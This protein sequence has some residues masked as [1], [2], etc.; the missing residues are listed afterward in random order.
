MI[1][2]KTKEVNGVTILNGFTWEISNVD[3]LIVG[4]AL[5]ILSQTID[6]HPSDRKDARRIV[7][8]IERAIWEGGEEEWK[9]QNITE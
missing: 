1:T 4:K 7:E 5:R 8:E 2:A 3:M 6:V 9:N